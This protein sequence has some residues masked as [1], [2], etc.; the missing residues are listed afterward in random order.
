MNIVTDINSWVQFRKSVQNKTIGFIPTMGNLHAGHLSLCRRARGK[1]DI[2]VVSIFINPYQFDQA[3]DFKQY[4]LA[5]D[6]TQDQTLLE[7]AGIDVLFLPTAE[8]LYQDNY[9]FQIIETAES[10]ILEG[11]HRPGHFTGVLTIVLKLCNLIMPT[12]AYF[13]EKDYQQYLLVKKMVQALFL[14]IEII[15]CKTVRD[16]DGLAYSSRNTRL[17][18]EERKQA[19]LFAEILRSGQNALQVEKILLQ[20]GFAVEYVADCWGRRLAAI[21]LGNVRLIDNIEIK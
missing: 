12:R 21:K 17:T 5:Q 20:L 18:L 13:G 2:T 4:Q 14:P 15:A 11:A 9:E 19:A 3:E 8:M 6:L 7:S 1:N 16:S 10:T